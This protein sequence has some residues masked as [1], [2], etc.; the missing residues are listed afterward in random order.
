MSKIEAIV[1]RDSV[2]TS[3]SRLITW[4][5]E[6]PKFLVAQVNT[7][8]A[9]VKSWESS[10]AVPVQRNIERVESNPFVPS[11]FGKNKPGMVSDQEVED[12]DAAL[13]IWSSATYW[14]L[15]YAKAMQR[16]GVHK[17]HAN[18]LLEPFLTVRGVITAT[19]TANFF[20]LR[21][22]H[23]AQPEMQML[24]R[25]M[26]ESME[27]SRPARL[28]YDEWHTPYSDGDRDEASARVARSSYRKHDGS[29]AD[30]VE[31][32]RLAGRLLTDKHMT[33]FEH[34]AR[35]MADGEDQIG[36]LIGW[37]TYRHEIEMR[38]AA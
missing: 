26:R 23:D 22:A 1:I 7:H 9:L 6:A 3:G 18:R 13:Q 2:S 37:R 5:V 33:P 24:A 28:D 38:E 12:A 36:A 32:R 19:D 11:S 15:Y 34:V 31:D 14:A 35:P 8:R 4:Q 20:A 27:A 30:P 21:L 17:Q 25:A 10:R 29:A 16:I